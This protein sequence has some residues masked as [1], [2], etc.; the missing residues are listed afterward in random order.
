MIKVLQK[1]KKKIPLQ[2]T[3]TIISIN[4]IYFLNN[5]IFVMPPNLSTH[6]NLI[7]LCI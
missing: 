5:L 3:Y 7:L 6:P 1:K 4:T 2:F